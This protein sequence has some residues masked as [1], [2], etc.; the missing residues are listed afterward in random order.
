MSVDP[1]LLEAIASLTP[2]GLMAAAVVALWRRGEAR[3]AAH[4]AEV[5]ALRAEGAQATRELAARLDALTDRILDGFEAQL[6]TRAD[7][8]PPKSDS[9]PAPARASRSAP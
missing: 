3:E 1:A 4:A 5:A 8:R 6:R 9:Q 7:G 2:S